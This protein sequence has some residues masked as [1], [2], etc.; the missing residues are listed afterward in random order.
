MQACHKEDFVKHAVIAIAALDKS[1]E[2]SATSPP[3][4][5]RPQDSL[6]TRV[7]SETHHTAALKEYS[8]ALKL[9]RC[10]TPRDE[11][12]GTRN[13]LLAC[14]LTICFENF[15]GT[16]RNALTQA[17]IGATLFSNWIQKEIQK[18]KKIIPRVSP[19]PDAIE[20]VLV[21]TFARLDLQ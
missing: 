12:E 17:H 13:T 6:K 18:G 2:E 15:Y 14:L 19:R 9:M 11:D 20:T 8:K 3:F 7:Q 4:G 1:I 5:I 16:E 21:A 10:T